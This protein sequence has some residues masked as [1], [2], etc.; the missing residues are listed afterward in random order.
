[1]EDN[2]DDD[3]VIL[4]QTSDI[5]Q[6][7]VKVHIG[8]INKPKGSDGGNGSVKNPGD[9]S[10]DGV[11][12]KKKISGSERRRRKKAKAAL[13]TKNSEHTET[14]RREMGGKRV[15]SPGVEKT[16]PPA[17]RSQTM[18]NADPEHT[19]KKKEVTQQNKKTLNEV[20]MDSLTYVI[21]G[22]DRMLSPD[23]VNL[24]LNNVIWEL[25]RFIGTQTMAPG[26]KGKRIGESELELRCANS[27]TEEWL[28]WVV[29]RLKPFK[30]ASLT[31]M[32]K[33]D[34]VNRAMVRMSVVVPWSTTGNYFL[35]VLRS[36]NPSL[37]TRCWDIKYTEDRG[38]STAIFLKVDVESA[39]ILRSNNF[40]AFW[41]LDE[42]TFVPKRSNQAPREKTDTDK[43]TV[44]V[45]TQQISDGKDVEETSAKLTET[46]KTEENTS[47][48]KTG[49]GTPIVIDNPFMGFGANDTN[50]IEPE[51][52]E[53]NV[54]TITVTISNPGATQMEQ[55]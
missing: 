21:V 6:N 31:L 20:V 18:R 30:G 2:T 12:R 16:T 24:I 38:D 23:Q 37:K 3:G 22:K 1:M 29:P 49:E 33:S 27:R 55:N 41:L 51:T 10:K 5:S 47:P 35:D 9:T 36:N 19:L 28:Q 32:R 34:W 11:I 50:I 48:S 52:D 40:K 54:N 25:E 42:I 7:S 26:F 4:T 14:N 17:K 13:E 45:D 15:R 46:N 39:E 8:K 44:Q 43:Q 53:N